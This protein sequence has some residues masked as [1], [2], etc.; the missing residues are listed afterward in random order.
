MAQTLSAAFLTEFGE[1]DL[2]AFLEMARL[3]LLIAPDR[4]AEEMDLSDDVVVNLHDRLF[5]FLDAEVLA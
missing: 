5:H 3:G 2:L 4:I 1:G